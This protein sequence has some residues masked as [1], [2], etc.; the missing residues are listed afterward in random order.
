MMGQ[1]GL[2]LRDVHSVEVTHGRLWG[3][4][5]NSEWQ[6]MENGRQ[7]MVIQ[8]N[9]GDRSWGKIDDGC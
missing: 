8:C 5:E 2:C 7:W 9:D 3:M 6:T 4:A 1:S